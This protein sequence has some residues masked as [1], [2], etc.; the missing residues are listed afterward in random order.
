MKIDKLDLK[1]DAEIGNEVAVT[2]EDVVNK[3]NELIEAHNKQEKMIK[4]YGEINDLD[5]DRIVKI[6]KK[7]DFIMDE[8]I[9]QKQFSEPT[10]KELY[11]E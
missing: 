11:K 6:N 5:D 2:H 7:I 8:V 1:L 4:L 3:L 10:L 9:V